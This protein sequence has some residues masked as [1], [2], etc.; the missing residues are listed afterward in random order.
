[1]LAISG[2]GLILPALHFGGGVIADRRRRDWTLRW[3]LLAITFW[4]D[5]PPKLVRFRSPERRHSAGAF[6]FAHAAVPKA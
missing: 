6:G 3:G 5:L 2:V 4:N 1:M